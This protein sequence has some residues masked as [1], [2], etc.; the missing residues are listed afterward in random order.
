MA[1]YKMNELHLHLSDES[2]PPTRYSAFRV[3]SK[4]FPGLAAKDLCYTQKEIRELQDFAKARGITIT[5]EIDMPGHAGSL[6]NY[7]PELKHPRS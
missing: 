1:W 7:W 6:T 3:E 2:G 4:K 5:P